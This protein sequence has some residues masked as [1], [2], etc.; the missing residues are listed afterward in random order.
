MADIAY[1][2]LQEEKERARVVVENHIDAE[3]GYLFTNDLDY[4]T[5]RTNILPV[6]TSIHK[7]S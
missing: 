1:R 6:Q 4:L 3:L 5:N 7:E 2:T